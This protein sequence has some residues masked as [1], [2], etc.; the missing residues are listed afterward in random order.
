[1]KAPRRSVPRDRDSRP[2]ALALVVASLALLASAG[3]L[4]P[5]LRPRAQPAAAGV[6]GATVARLAALEGEVERLRTL[7]GTGPATAAPRAREL[8]RDWLAA[9]VEEVLDRR[10]R[11]GQS[12]ARAAPAGAAA[13]GDPAGAAAVIDQLLRAGAGPRSEQLWEELRALDAIDAAVARFEELAAGN[14]GSPDAQTLLGTAY[15]QQM[16]AANDEQQ[17]IELGRKIEAQ[18]DKALELQPDHWEARFRKAVGL[19]YGDALSGRRGAA[20]AQFERLVRQQE[21]LSPQPHHAQTFLYLGR[22][23]AEQGDRERA[24]EIWRRGLASHPQQQDL[25]RMLR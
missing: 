20:I 18:F 2:A 1:M 23:Y 24:E 16:L 4:W 25:M 6:D 14:P 17:R 19:S 21:N 5:A 8:D 13:G 15:I 7:Q 12:T 9:L 11:G 3:A 10:A 22:L